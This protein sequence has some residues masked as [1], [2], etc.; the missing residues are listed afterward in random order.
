MGI[1]HVRLVEDSESQVQR[2]LER[3]GGERP[4][5]SRLGGFWGRT[6]AAAPPL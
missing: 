2:L 3:R 1:M 4:S 6:G 5:A